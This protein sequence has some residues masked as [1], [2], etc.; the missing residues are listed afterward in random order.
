MLAMLVDRRQ[1]VF[2]QF[3]EKHMSIARVGKMLAAWAVLAAA[4]LVVSASGE[5][6]ARIVR[7][8]EVQG[9][10]QLDRPIKIW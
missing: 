5:S 3:L 9:G 8:S 4:F 2:R 10:V 6:K 1:F 7:L